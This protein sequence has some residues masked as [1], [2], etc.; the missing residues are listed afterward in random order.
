MTQNPPID[1]YPNALLVGT[2]T[3]EKVTCK[4]SAFPMSIFARITEI[5]VVS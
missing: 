2:G 1:S 3:E 4:T 5:V